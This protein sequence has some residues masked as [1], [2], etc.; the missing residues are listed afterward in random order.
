MT[1]IDPKE[2]EPWFGFALLEVYADQTGK[3]NRGTVLSVGPGEDDD[4]ALIGREVL[5]EVRNAL[6]AGKSD[7]NPQLI[8]AFVPISDI[9]GLVAIPGH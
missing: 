4:E 2:L 3:L 1:T 8:Y 7:T 5:F 9:A 6:P